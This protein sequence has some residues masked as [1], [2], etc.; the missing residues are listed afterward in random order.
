[1]Q[2]F[3]FNFETNIPIEK[4][5]VTLEKLMCDED[6]KNKFP[7]NTYQDLLPYIERIKKG[8]KDFADNGSTLGPIIHAKAVF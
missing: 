8:K 4:F 3:D 6:F 1:M 2:L 5:R 7:L